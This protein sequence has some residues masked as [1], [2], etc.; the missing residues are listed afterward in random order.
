MMAAPIL[1][2]IVT[3][4]RAALVKQAIASA[5]SQRGCIARVSIIDDDSRDSTPELSA[6]FPE[7]DWIKC[8]PAKGYLAARNYWMQSTKAEYFVSLD[9]DARF[10]SGDEVAVAVATLARRPKVA[11]VA[12]D[13]LSPD[14]PNAVVRTEPTTVASFIGC[15]HVLRTAAVR[16]VGLYEAVPG[17]Y[18]GEEKDLSLRLL[19]AGHEIVALPGVHVWHEKTLVARVI[20]DQH[21]SGICNDLVMTL[22]RTPTV[23]LPAA[24]L[25]KS[26]RH[27]RFSWR[28]GLTRPCLQAFAWFARSIPMAWRSRRPVKTKTL[29]AFMRLGRS[30]PRQ[31]RAVWKLTNDR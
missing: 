23:L 26:Y 15:G 17:R 25:A 11:V 16:S 7:V 2:G 13:I 20:P 24:L 30:S 9:D 18:G 27:F 28:N 14:R 5:L 10:V 21:R 3:R 22:R 4:D 19:D 12:F 6:Q 8:S 31:H 29:R 1:I